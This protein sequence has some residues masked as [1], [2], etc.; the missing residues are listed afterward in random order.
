MPSIVSQRAGY[1]D[2]GLQWSI[3]L[4]LDRNCDHLVGTIIHLPPQSEV[5]ID[6]YTCKSLTGDSIACSRNAPANN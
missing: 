2:S 3:L 1:P 6:N 5:E 4:N